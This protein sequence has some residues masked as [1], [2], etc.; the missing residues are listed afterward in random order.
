[1]MGRFLAELAGN[2]FFCLW[3][4]RH[5]LY[6]DQYGILK[7]PKVSKKKPK[8]LN[9][10]TLEIKGEPIRYILEDGRMFEG[11]CKVSNYY[12]NPI[13]GKFLIARWGQPYRMLNTLECK[14]GSPWKDWPNVRVKSRTL[15]CKDPYQYTVIRGPFKAYYK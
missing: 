9:S 2:A 12:E 7:L 3:I 8:V 14:D 4:P 6:V 10:Y 5:S 11:S 1:M 15:I 13:S